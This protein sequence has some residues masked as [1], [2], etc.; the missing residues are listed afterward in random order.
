[1][2]FDLYH[3][4]AYVFCCRFYELT[5]TRLNGD[6]EDTWVRWI[7]RVVYLKED[8]YGCIRAQFD[9]YH[10]PYPE[11]YVK[12]SPSRDQKADDSSSWKCLE[13]DDIGFLETYIE[14][15]EHDQ[16]D[17]KKKK[18]EKKLNKERRKSKKKKWFK[19]DKK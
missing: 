11:Y 16:K 19:K 2:H 13:L 18:K 4:L 12:R 3:N 6:L 7:E 8:P 14:Q 17:S 5:N 9:E 1:M 15:Y 10:I